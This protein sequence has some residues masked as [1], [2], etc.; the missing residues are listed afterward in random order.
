[1]DDL[2]LYFCVQKKIGNIIYTEELIKDGENVEV[3]KDN[4]DVYIQKR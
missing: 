2:G 1:L 3:S 4:L